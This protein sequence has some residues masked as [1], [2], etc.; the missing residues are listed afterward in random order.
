MAC[1]ASLSDRGLSR[2]EYLSILANTGCHILL[3]NYISCFPSH[4]P[5]WVP[6]AARIPVTQAAAPPP[7]L[8]LT[9][10][11][12]RPS[13]QPQELNPSG[14]PTCRG[15]N[16]TTIET[17]GHMWLRKK[18]L[19]LP[20]S[21][22]SFRLNPHNQLRRLCVYE[23]YK[24]P[25]RAP[26]KENA[27]ALIAVVVGSKNTQEWD[28]IIIWPTPTAGPEI[29]TVLEGI[30]R[31]GQALSLWSRSTDSKTLYYQRT[32]PREYQI[33]RIHRK[34]TTWIQDPASPNHQQH[35]VQDASS[36]QQIKQTY[37]PNHQQTG[38]S[39]HSAMPIRGKTNKQINTKPQ[40]KSHPIR[41]LHKPLDQP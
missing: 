30:L 35:P 13:G 33:V 4:Q 38:L 10:A 8:A 29:S 17:Q 25:L 5:P 3:E 22:T 37:Q 7:H 9:E 26:T 16:K 31:R 27:L 20:T 39:P 14:R 23:I 40:H 15:G 21:C 12:P 2:Q 19:N 28:N 18:T 41:S 34:E 1:Q 6:G 36:K 32:N 24:R 11:N